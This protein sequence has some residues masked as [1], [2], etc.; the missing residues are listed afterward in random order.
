LIASIHDNGRMNAE[1]LTRTLEEFLGEASGAVVIE[2]GAVMF[3]R[4]EVFDIRRAQ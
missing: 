2:D 3:G 4:V 1:S